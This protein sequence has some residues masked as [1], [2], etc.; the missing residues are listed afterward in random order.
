VNPASGRL[1]EILGA[2]LAKSA[3]GTE[4]AQ[5]LVALCAGALPVSGAGIALMTDAGPAGTV[6]ASDASALE[7]EE[8]Q[9]GLGEGPCVDAS[10]TGRPVLVPDL[11][12]GA[13]RRWPAFTEGARAAGLR[14]V[15]AL[16]L[17]VGG[18][19][20][21]VL[22]LHSRT[23]G[24]LSAE[25]L[26]EALRFADAATVVLLNL[27]S[28]DAGGDLPLDSLTVQDN[29]AVVHQATGVVSVQ[30]DVGLEEALALLRARAYAD[31]RP[32]GAVAGDVLTGRIYFGTGSDAR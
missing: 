8:L 32:I 6:S 13:A 27:Q 12:D 26:A 24:V 9:F 14:A 20:L 31:Q 30:A 1:T 19:R 23:T 7:L 18:I 4:P 29:R 2:V 21:G 15:F 3:D 5:S 17:R 16:P 25:E 11:S 28:G 22:D 10:R